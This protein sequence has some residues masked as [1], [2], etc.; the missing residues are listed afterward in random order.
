MD[1]KKYTEANREAWNQAIV[2]HRQGAKINLF[3]EFKKPGYFTLD[4]VVT[5]KLKM[6]GINGKSVCQICCNNGR[7]LLSI[8]NLG[9]KDG[10]GFDI[11]DE[12]INEANQLRDVAGLKCEFIRSDIYEI[13]DKY[14]GKFDLVFFSIG[15][16]CWLP[17]L[18]RLFKLVADMLKDGGTLLIYELHPITY[19][20]AAPGEKDFDADNPLKV[21]NS[22][23]QN[24][25]LVSTEGF[26]YVGK[27]TYEAKPSFD[28]LHT[29]GHI[30]TSIAS[31][32]III[33][34]VAEYNHD[35]SDL[36]EHLEPDSK[37]PLSYTLIGKKAK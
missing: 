15:A 37:I 6:I 26:D 22:Y 7:E 10:V 17:D 11:S 13:G 2:I 1:I 29:F 35:I 21:C 28:F 34:E 31:S 19:L 18:N 25:P 30:L 16:L 4:D 27:T 8:I 3:E 5:G 24:E 12:A 36:F 32:G 23:F 20:F 9:A 33:E 14:K